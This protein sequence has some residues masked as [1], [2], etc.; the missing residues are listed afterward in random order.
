MGKMSLRGQQGARLLQERAQI[1]IVVE[2]PEGR[3]RLELSVGLGSPKRKDNLRRA[4]LA[5]IHAQQKCLMILLWM[6][7]GGLAMDQTNL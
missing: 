6:V 5:N 2:N 4:Y 3:T 1:L 7:M